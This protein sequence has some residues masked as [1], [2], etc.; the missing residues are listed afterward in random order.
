MEVPAPP[1]AEPVNRSLLE[2]IGDAG[3]IYWGLFLGFAAIVVAY[4]WWMWRSER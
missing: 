3:F 1:G 4:L 2:A